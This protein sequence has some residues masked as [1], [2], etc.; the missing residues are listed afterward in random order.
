MF[1]IGT[2]FRRAVS[3]EEVPE[4]QCY[5]VNI[6][7]NSNIFVSVLPHRRYLYFDV[8]VGLAWS[9]DPE[10]CAGRS[11]AAGMASRARRVRV[12]TQTKRDTLVL[13]VGG[14]V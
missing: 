2:F 14:W 1:S 4:M 6:G 7:E 8:V 3:L 9:N 10:S 12:M 13:Q 11:D 5:I